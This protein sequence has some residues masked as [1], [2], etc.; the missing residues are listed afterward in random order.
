[1]MIPADHS[2]L[3]VVELPNGPRVPRRELPLRPARGER[4]IEVVLPGGS[5]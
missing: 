4:W 2:Y 1:M 3:V 5:K